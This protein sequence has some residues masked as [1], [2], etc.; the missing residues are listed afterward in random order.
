MTLRETYRRLKK[1]IISNYKNIVNDDFE[2][3]LVI[4]FIYQIVYL[5]EHTFSVEK[6]YLLLSH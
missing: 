3:T 1:R 6:F 4:D 5:S 2:Q